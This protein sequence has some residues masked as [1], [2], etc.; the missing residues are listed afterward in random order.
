MLRLVTR[1]QQINV[2]DWT[3]VIE[4]YSVACAQS[5]M[6]F[7]ALVVVS[8]LC[9]TVISKKDFQLRHAMPGALLMHARIAS[10]RRVAGGADAGRYGKVTASMGRILR[11]AKWEILTHVLSISTSLY[12]ASKYSSI[13]AVTFSNLET[14]LL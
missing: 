2:I 12:V 8:W 1:P 4:F 3:G 14:L 9:R 5:I 13:P 7:V 6:C 10:P 11:K